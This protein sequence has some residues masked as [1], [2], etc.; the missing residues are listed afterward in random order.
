MPF[1]DGVGE[2]QI[3]H[4]FTTEVAAIKKAIALL[5]SKIMLTFVI[6]SKRISAR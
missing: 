5:N 1:R 2:G 6:T 4:V 3:P